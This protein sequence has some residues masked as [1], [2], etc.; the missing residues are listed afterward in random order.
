[1]SEALFTTVWY[2]LVTVIQPALYAFTPVLA[3]SSIAVKLNEGSTLLSMSER[4]TSSP[5]SVYSGANRHARYS[6]SAIA[7]GGRVSP[8][9]RY[10]IRIVFNDIIITSSFEPPWFGLICLL[11]C[12]STIP[13]LASKRSIGGVFVAFAHQKFRAR[14]KRSKLTHLVNVFFP[15]ICTHYVI[16]YVCT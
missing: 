6:A 1:M 10:V 14:E 12:F 2:S 5:A 3:S 13:G 15:E 4:S 9:M 11:V 7:S 8:P 16:W